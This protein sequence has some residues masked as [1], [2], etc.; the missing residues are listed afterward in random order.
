MHDN[1]FEE[2]ADNNG[3]YVT[4]NNERHYVRDIMDDTYDTRGLKYI[5]GNKYNNALSNLK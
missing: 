5:D 1:I 2:N 4:I 3:A